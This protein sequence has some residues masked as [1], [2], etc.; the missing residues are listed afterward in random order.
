MVRIFIDTM[1]LMMPFQFKVD[2]FSE[3]DRLFGNYE[4]CIS[5]ITF[6]ELDNIENKAAKG[7]DKLAVKAVR[8]LIEQKNLIII[9]SNER[10]VDDFL[11]KNAEDFDFVATQDKELKRKLKNRTKFIVL[12]SGKYLENVL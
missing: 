11:V 5:N 2:I 6:K 7:A 9:E 3:L 4:A 8:K 12:R 1:F 10:L